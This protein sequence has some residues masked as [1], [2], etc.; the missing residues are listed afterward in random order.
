MTEAEKSRTPVI[1]PQHEYLAPLHFTLQD[2]GRKVTILGH[3][4]IKIFCPRVVDVHTA[5][6]L[7]EPR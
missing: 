1:V 2:A 3:Q 7:S 5:L 4:V 6:L